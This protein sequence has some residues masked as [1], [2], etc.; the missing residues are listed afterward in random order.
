MASAPPTLKNVPFD[1]KMSGSGE[2]KGKFDKESKDEE[3][4]FDNETDGGLIV[5]FILDDDDD[6]GL[7]FPDDHTR[8][9]WVKPVK[10]KNEKT[11]PTEGDK[12]DVFTPLRVTDNNRTL[13]VRNTNQCRATFKFAL[14]FTEK[15]HDSGAKLISWDPIGENRNGGS[16]R[17][18]VPPALG[19]TVLAAGIAG[20]AVGALAGYLA[21]QQQQRTRD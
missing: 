7:L 19:G 4:V 11:C 17:S 18:F 3:V 21:C 12:W 14:N 1:L 5:R 2:L 8:A 16:L 6:T 15:P 9:I 13:E 20:A 10:D